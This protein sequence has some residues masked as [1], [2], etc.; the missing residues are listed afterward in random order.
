[1]LQKEKRINIQNYQRVE[2]KFTPKIP[3]LKKIKDKS[4]INVRYSLIS[5]F[6]FAHIYWD[7]KEYELVYEVEEPY[8]NEKEIIYKNQI[9]SAMRD[10]INFDTVIEKNQETLLDYIDKR[11]KILAIELGIDLPY[12]SYQKIFYYLARDFIGFNET[13]PLLRDYF[14][15]DI[16]CNGIN[17]PIYIVHRL[18]RN[19]KTNIKFKNSNKL[20][21]FVEKL[22]Q[23]CGKYI[24]Y[25][26]PI[27]DGSL[28]D[29]SRVNATYTKDI[30]SR[31]PTFTIRKFTKTPWTPTQL[32]SL[33]TLSAEM[34][35]Y[36]WIL[37]QYK[38]NLLITGGT[39]SGKTTLLNAIVFFI[40][41]EA[42]VVSIEDTRELN[43][44]R[45]NWLP[46]IVR[47]AT[48]I[49]K[50]GEVNLFTLLKSSFR[51]NPDYVIVGE[52]RGKETYVL[53]Q[54]MASGHSSLSTMHAD[55]VDT[56]IKR[57]ETPPIELSP[58]LLNI[59]DCVCIMTHAIV[60]KQETRKLKEIAEIV[61]INSN[62]IALT[63][64]PFKW[65][66]RDDQFYF[67]KNS[68]IFEKISQ[69]YGLRLEE[70]ELEFKKRVR[71]I[72][73]LYKN[74]IFKFEEVQD[75]INQY[76]KKPEQTLRKFGIM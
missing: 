43:L 52:V 47:N 68:K 65:N 1:M 41:P 12:E 63:N 57:L 23:R 45:E 50:A 49:E 27:L 58:T 70:L 60:N 8:L 53:F 20:S 33:K 73:A 75:V 56:V 25:S 10:M 5:P 14:V 6:S 38:M 64:T 9:I 66:P 67:K 26:N 62:G 36:L 61:N 42:R 3:H 24:S 19:I 15:E 44:P 2:I 40:P 22:A 11:F 72:Y 28:P 74:K 17:T 46:S 71:L 69:R 37:I 32:I 51:Q 21:N 55:S 13:D 18:Y 59:L 76:Y 54:G 16:E 29:G 7:P 31:G 48:G 4:K 30:T 34:L 35:A 39:S